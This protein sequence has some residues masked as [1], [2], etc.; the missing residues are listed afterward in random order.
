[1][2]NFFSGSMG[3][4]IDA[5]DVTPS[6]A[7]NAGRSAR[8]FA[9]R[10]LREGFTPFSG[11][12]VVPFS[13]SERAILD[14]FLQADLPMLRNSLGDIAQQDALG[15]AEMLLQPAKQ[16]SIQSGI[17]SIR[18]RMGATGN[19]FSSN[20]ALEEGRTVGDIEAGFNQ[21]L[22][23]LLPQLQAQ[24]MA[25][26]QQLLGQTGTALGL[27]SIPRN[28]SQQD[29]NARFQEFLRT[30]PSGGPL[31]ALLGLSGNMTPLGSVSPGIYGPSMFD[32]L[33]QL[34]NQT[35][36]GYQNYGPR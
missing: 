4:G 31:Q 8:K 36:Q 19:L 6:F 7:R 24:R 17:N 20:L 27:A 12:F 26:A 1:M 15:R 9:Q 22:A 29:L 13:D 35:M 34:G 28:I 21:S 33:L 25:A 2:S 32:S 23:A 11:D 3:G 14:Q 10:G 5:N 16:R 30:T 18:E